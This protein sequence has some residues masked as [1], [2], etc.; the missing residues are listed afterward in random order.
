MKL[1]FVVGNKE[2]HDIVFRWNQLWGSL[3]ISVDG[4]TVER[5]LLQLASPNKPAQSNRESTADTWVIFG[6]AINLVDRW[7]FA[8][9]VTEQHTI[10]IEK[11]R[12]KWNAGLRRHNYRVLVDGTEIINQSGY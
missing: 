10:R 11:R 2:K 9:G 7:E 8:V 3:R 6:K 1:S 5:R 4:N 12:P